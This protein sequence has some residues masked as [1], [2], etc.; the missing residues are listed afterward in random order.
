[1]GGSKSDGSRLADS[2]SDGSLPSEMKSPFSCVLIGDESLL[3]RC[4]EILQAMR[5]DIRAVVSVHPR[6]IS[7]AGE[8][9]ILH[10]RPGRDLES[11]LREFEF[12][13][14]F[15]VANLRMLNRGILECPRIAA[16]NFHD[17]PLPAYAGLHSPAWAIAKGEPQHGITFHAMNEEADTGDIYCQQVFDLAPDET[18]LT[19]N[20]RCYEAAA[21]TFS[22]LVDSIIAGTARP[23]PQDL[24]NR[25]YFGRLDRPEAAGILDWHRS[26]N[27]NE[28]LVRAADF[29][30]HEN[31]FCAA[32]LVHGDRVVCVTKASRSDMTGEPGTILEITPSHLVI[33]SD[34]KDSLSIESVTSSRGLAM[35]IPELVE[36]LDLCVGMRLDSPD[37]QAREQLTILAREAIPSESFW[38]RRLR[39]F[40]PI[41]LPYTTIRGGESATPRMETLD[42]EVPADFTRHFEG[43]ESAGLIAAFGTY[44]ARVGRRADLDL[45]YGHD[46]LYKTSERAPGFFASSIP[47]RL[48]IDLE[49]D[50]RSCAASI[51]A[52]IDQIEEHGSHLQ[53]VVARVPELAND[54]ALV[55]GSLGSVGIASVID[56]ESAPP[57]PAT[58]LTLIVCRDGRAARFRYDAARLEPKS[59]R[60]I[61]D[62]FLLL[63]ENMAAMEAPSFARASILAPEEQRLILDQ[64]N[65]SSVEF[66]QELCIHDAFLQQVEQTPEA[67]ALVFESESLCYREL[68]RRVDTLAKYL[69]GLG[70]GPDVLVG[71][72]LERS[73]EMVVGLLGILRA[74]GAYVPLDPGYPRERIDYMV[75]DSNLSVVLTQSRF[76][77]DLPSTLERIVLDRGDLERNEEPDSISEPTVRADNLAYVIYTSGSTGKPKGVMVEH[78]NVA[79]F[80]AG[81]DERIPHDPPETWLAVTS[82]SFDISVL[83]LLW[84]LCRG[85]KVV[86]H[87]EKNRQLEVLPSRP[88]TPWRPMSFGIA[89]WGSD[90]GEGSRKYELMLES[91]RF[92]DAHGFESFHTP[93]RHF[94]AFGGPFPNP[95]ITSAAIAAVTSKIKIR[96]SSCIL[97]LH[98]PIRVAEEWAVVDNLSNGRA[99]IAFASGWQPNDFVIRPESY[100]SAKSMMFENT[101]IVCRLWRGESVEFENSKGEL[102]PTATLPRPVQKELNVWITAAG[103]VETFKMAGTKGYHILTHL[104]G[105]SLE[106]AAEKI[107][108]YR[109]AREAAGHDPAT[110]RATLMLH[111]YVGEDNDQVRELVRGPMKEYLASAVS[112][113]MGFA[114]TFPAFKRP[115][116][117]DSKP[118]DIDLSSLSEEEVDTILEFAF[119]RYYETSGLFGTPDLCADM[120]DRVRAA[121][122]DEICALV[123]FGLS[124]DDVLVGLKGLKTVRDAANQRPEPSAVTVEAST[125]DD[126]SFETL[127]REHSI[128]HMQCTPAMARML[129]TNPDTQNSVGA[130]QNLIIGGEAFPPALARDL[131]ESGCHSLT[132]MYGPTETTIWSTSE[133]VTGKPDSISIGRPIANTRLYILDEAGQPLPVGLPGELVI[134]GKGVVRGYLGR[135]A[136]TAERFVPDVFSDCTDA[137]LYRTGDLA[138]WRSDGRIE[139]L[140]RLDH[141]VKIRG[142]RIELGE[143]EA[144]LAALSEIR[145]CVVIA[146]GEANEPERAPQLIAYVV[147]HKPRSIETETMRAALRK[148]LPEFMMPSDFIMLDRLPTTPNGKLD[149]KALPAPEESANRAGSDLI[150]PESELEQLIERVWT[151]VLRIERVGI[152][153]N[154]FDI[155]GHSLLIVQTH[156]KLR[157]VCSRPVSLTDLYRFPTIRH[158]AE[159]LSGDDD[160]QQ[161]TADSRDRGQRRRQSAARRRKRTTT[162]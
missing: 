65:E 135:Q 7:W 11:S 39:A 21:E 146:R 96:A 52:A 54:P 128:S 75:E 145:D 154:F 71:L 160:S 28:R 43:V 136:L 20:A 138:C 32:K 97:P 41:E 110:G 99:E 14:L 35:S 144:R 132:N 137:R 1:M 115:G 6:I 51:Q 74:G 87:H 42:L 12:D 63:L 57:S 64:W 111:T 5:C 49:A 157:E 9:S 117:P 131:N 142:H 126:F 30:H 109:E 139:F 89:M 53:D 120:V 124:K 133:E 105:Q 121:G 104:L 66:D 127:V 100:E 58:A 151:D 16:I 92:G 156:R 72:Y 114:W 116:G 70:V 50:A 38:I 33:A 88:S 159:F 83:E 37:P 95:S 119:E 40:S 141:Q 101:D 158:L 60:A 112:L 134:G 47:L 25:S 118:E 36:A 73:I 56:L 10:L 62:Q 27:E 34:R 19:L 103:N 93:E 102:V 69:R 125:T 80:F 150:A 15:S 26:A 155:G 77:D 106:E 45:A 153:E 108:A 91:A 122:V 18:S 85:F 79:N 24:A 48:S 78:R 84:T 81:M 140:G 143:I 3:I 67:T 29:G 162:R 86:I 129:L 17:G 82:L 59:A 113:V 68:N 130:I 55:A 61:R 2:L 44:L 94:G 152:D 90:A 46:A 147:T 107:Q 148:S 31:T 76:V 8:N 13:Y 22:V 149:R 4:A 98:H 161:T 23:Q 123:D